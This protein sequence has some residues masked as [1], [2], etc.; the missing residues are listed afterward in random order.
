MIVVT[1]EMNFAKEVGSRVVFMDEG[2]IVEEGT[3][4]ELLKKDKGYYKNLYEVQ[5][6]KEEAL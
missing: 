2:K 4:A 5:F 1:H 6:L 3:H